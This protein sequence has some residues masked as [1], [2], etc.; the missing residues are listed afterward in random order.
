MATMKLGFPTKIQHLTSDEASIDS[1]EQRLQF[2][3]I[4]E[5]LFIQLLRLERR[6]A[7]RSGRCSMFILIAAED[8]PQPLRG[9]LL[10]RVAAE[11]ASSTRE[12]DVLGWY[13][14]NSTLGLLMTEITCMNAA[15][16]D[17][18]MA[19]VGDA[20]RRGAGSD[21]AQRINLIFR[22]FPQTPS[23]EPSD[24]SEPLFFPEFAEI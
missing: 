14:R 22:T 24:S 5:A 6:R 13:K 1:F 19:K 8:F 10:Q 23:E 12:T 15:T 3:V 11:I 20:V 16:I 21:A 2:P 17:L 9:A 18:L 7:E 4:Q